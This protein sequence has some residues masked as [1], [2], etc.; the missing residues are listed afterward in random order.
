VDCAVA[1]GRKY[2]ASASAVLRNGCT[3]NLCMLDPSQSNGHH[4]DAV[5]EPPPEIPALMLPVKAQA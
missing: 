5:L 2:I 4:P 1:A 3:P